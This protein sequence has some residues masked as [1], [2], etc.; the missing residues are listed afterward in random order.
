MDNGEQ[1]EEPS[2]LQEALWS[3][4]RRLGASTS[5]HVLFTHPNVVVG[6]SI[7]TT[8]YFEVKTTLTCYLRQSFS[9]IAN[10][11]TFFFHIKTKADFL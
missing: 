8:Q 1:P 10:L 5:M 11:T 6:L 4:L 3:H 2:L 7:E 9:K